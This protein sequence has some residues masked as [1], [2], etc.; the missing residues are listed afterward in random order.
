MVTSLTRTRSHFIEITESDDFSSFSRLN[1]RIKFRSYDR[2]DNGDLFFFIKEG[3]QCPSDTTNLYR[4]VSASPNIEDIFFGNGDI[5]YNLCY[6]FAGRKRSAVKS[7][8]TL[9][10]ANNLNIMTTCAVG[11]ANANCRR[12]PGTTFTPIRLRH[13]MV[14]VTVMVVVQVVSLALFRIPTVL[15]RFHINLAIVCVSA[16]KILLRIIK[17]PIEITKQLS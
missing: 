11:F 9:Y 6:I 7:K 10:N 5:V 3:E 15:I 16:I 4:N 14:M 13:V 17:M 1:Y 2:E 12:C 8:P